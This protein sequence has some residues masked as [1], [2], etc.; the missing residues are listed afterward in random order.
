MMKHKAGLQVVFAVLVVA[1]ALQANG[2]ILHPSEPLPSFEVATVKPWRA[3]PRPMTAPGSPP[4]IPVMIDPGQHVQ[5]QET[6]RVHFI[7]QIGLL[8]M[9]AY[10][11]P[12]GSE[13][14]I[15]KGPQW[16][17]SESDRY[18]V[19]A[20]IDASRFAAM[21]KMTPEQQ[22]EQVELMEQSLLAERFNLKVHFEIRGETPIYALVVAKGGPKLSPSKGVE[23]TSLSARKD[24]IIAQAVT[25]DQFAHSPLWTPIGNRYVVDQTGLTG[26][27]DFT[28]KWRSDPLDESGELPD[29]FNAIQEQLGLKVI[30]SKAPLEVLVIDH[31]ER[32]SMN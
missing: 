26:T 6:D 17:E 25:L 11:L 27:Y 31:I 2:Q 19:E 12:I 32:P 10:N 4:V 1:C 13:R 14:R 16:V 8:I 5:V 3:D 20:K 29:L 7:G 24:E 15:L 18:A 30:D 28:L 21:R 23:T 9:K 22:Q